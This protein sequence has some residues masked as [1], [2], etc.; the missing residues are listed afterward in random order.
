MSEGQVKCKIISFRIADEEYSNLQTI[1]RKNGFPSVSH[2]TREALKCG[3]AEQLS[4]PLDAEMNRL[5][6]RLEALAAMI[7]KLVTRLRPMVADDKVAE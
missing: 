6:C 5:S 1:A 4:T 7:E 2:Y 3:P